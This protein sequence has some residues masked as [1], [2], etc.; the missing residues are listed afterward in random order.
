MMAKRR[1]GWRALWRVGLVL[2][3][4]WLLSIAFVVIWSMRDDASN[5]DA[6]VVLGAAQWD[7]RPS[8]VL[9]AR[10]EHAH[11]LWRKGHAPWLVLTGGVGQ[12]DTT[13]EAIVGKRFLTQLGVPEEKVLLEAEGRTTEQSMHGVAAMLRALGIKRVLLVSDPFHMLRL[14]VVA[15]SHGLIPHTSPTRTS[16]IS[17][18]AG[19]LLT[20]VLA[21]SLKVPFTLV[22]AGWAWVGNAES[23]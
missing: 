4:T 2:F 7:G 5:A 11:E 20:Y 15:R 10:L 21:E 23:R 1:T 19:E 3:V 12:G 9:R 16:P 6:I 13:S 18:N 14:E 22:T 8:P 17:R